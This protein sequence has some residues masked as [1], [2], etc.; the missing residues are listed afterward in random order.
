[1]F[2][3]LRGR[4]RIDD[5]GRLGEGHRLDPARRGAFPAT[6]GAGSFRFA[7]FNTALVGRRGADLEGPRR[8]TATPRQRVSSSK[9]FRGRA[10]DAA[11]MKMKI[12]EHEN[13]GKY[14]DDNVQFWLR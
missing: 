10:L 11:M 2:R 7:G 8:R 5:T 1:M 12:C 4:R 6:T 13:G 9:E 14:D 3:F